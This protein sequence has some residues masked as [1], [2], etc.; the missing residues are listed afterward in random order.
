MA[1]SHSRVSIRH[2]IW[3]GNPARLSGIPRPRTTRFDAPYSDGD[4]TYRSQH[5]VCD[6]VA[7]VEATAPD[8]YSRPV[9]DSPGRLPCTEHRAAFGVPSMEARHRHSRAGRRRTSLY[10]VDNRRQRCSTVL[11]RCR[12]LPATPNLSPPL[13]D[14]GLVTVIDRS[15]QLISYFDRLKVPGPAAD[16]TAD[17]GISLAPRPRPGPLLRC[18]QGQPAE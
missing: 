4:R 11:A 6:G 17:A 7:T 16:R 1:A 9:A 18:D 15:A 14:P 8:R 5:P 3:F 2:H 12:L 13:S 10:V